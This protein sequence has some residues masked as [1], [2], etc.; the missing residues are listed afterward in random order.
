MLNLAQSGGAVEYTCCIATYIYI[1]KYTRNIIKHND[2][3]QWT[4]EHTS[5]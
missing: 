2:E 4:N 3:L 5:L 1:Y